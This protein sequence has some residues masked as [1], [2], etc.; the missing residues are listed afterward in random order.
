MAGE[1]ALTASIMMNTARAADIGLG[2]FQKSQ[3]ITAQTSRAS[4]GL[5]VNFGQAKNDELVLE[6]YKI[7]EPAVNA[8]RD[9]A[10][11]R[12]KEEFDRRKNSPFG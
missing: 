12:L 8:I 11:K 2:K 7:E 4:M 5:P 3:A 9:S 1:V 10:E 6:K